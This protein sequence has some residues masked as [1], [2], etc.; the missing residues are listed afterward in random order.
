MGAVQN[1]FH[2]QLGVSLS[3]NIKTA[4]LQA[5]FANEKPFLPF[6]LLSELR[7]LVCVKH[8]SNRENQ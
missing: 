5:Q 3:G 4:R 1:G 7:C 8:F 2:V 6:A